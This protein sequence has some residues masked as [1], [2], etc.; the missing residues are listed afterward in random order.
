MLKVSLLSPFA[1]FRAETETPYL[2]LMP[3][4]VSP[5]RTVCEVADADE[6]LVVAATEPPPDPPGIVRV[7]PIRILL[8][9]K[10]FAL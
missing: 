2:R 9:L 10:P 5:D 1:L 6:L 7:C 4:S 3:Q 8:P